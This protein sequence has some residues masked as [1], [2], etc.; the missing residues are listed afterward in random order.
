MKR[1]FLPTCCALAALSIAMPAMAQTADPAAV[2]KTADPAAVAQTA[3]PA[4]SAAEPKAEQGLEDIIV[5]AQRRSESLQRAAVAVDVVTAGDLAQAGV[6]T[7]T[8]LNAAVPSLTVQQGGGANSAFFLRGVGNF[9]ANGYSDPAVAFNLDGVYIGRPSSTTTVFYDLER[10][11]VLKGPQGTLYGRNATGGAVNVIPMKP[12]IGET[13]IAVAAGYG[14]YDARDAEAVVNVALGAKAALRVAGKTVDRDGYNRDGTL[15]DVGQAVRAQLLLEATDRLTLRVAADYAHQGGV[16]PSGSYIGSEAATPGTAATATSPANYTYRPTGLD[17]RLGFRA[18][19]AQA[20]YSRVVI[21]GANINPAPLAAASLDNHYWGV[22]S[23]MTW[24]TEAGTLTVLPSFRRSTLSDVY[25]GPSFRAGLIEETDEQFSVE[26]RFAGKRIGPFD[27]L[28]GAYY[29]DERVD[30]QYALNQYQ[31]ISF[32]DFTSKTRSK[33]VFGRL[34]ANLTDRFRLVGGG[35]YTHDDKDFAAAVQAL[36]DVCTRPTGC[37]G[38]PSL[39]VVLRL[40]DVP[41]G[42]RAPGLAGAVPFGTNGNILLYSPTTID[43]SFAASRFTYR[44]AAEYDLGPRSLLY[45]SYETGYRSGGFSTATGRERYGPEFVDAITIGSKNRFFD[46]RV[47]INIEAFHWKY[48]DQQVSHFG[49]DGVG[50][51]NFF[52]ENIGASTIKGVDVE[53]QVLVT[54][55]TRLNGTVQYLDSTVDRFRYNLP[56]TATS[57][58]PVTGCAVTNGGSGTALTYQVDCSGKPGYNSPRWAVNAGIDQTIPLGALEVVLNG[59]LHYRAN[60]VVGFDYLPQQNTGANTTFDLGAS[61]GDAE[62]RWTL[63]GFVRNV[64]D[65]TIPSYV[66]YSGTLG[67]VVTAI[68]NSPRTYGAR[69]AYKF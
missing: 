48:R 59:A 21:P 41:N 47:Q 44:L 69:L 64:T 30:A 57:L 2:T 6:V 55:T 16:G 35:R 49:L 58:P 52:T 50:N 37:I 19:A 26:A 68:Y 43:Q 45:A 17:P 20:F 53:T 18:P 7:A 51:N 28:I 1:P 40:A 13:S 25:P 15:D 10:I 22:L 34:T 33:A 32:Q 62:D 9:T 42:P 36:V 31:L 24:R 3:D 67:G 14:N 61:I 38:G 56:R 4:A 63:S 66:Q 29:F 60:A 54:P 23:E 65:E 46:N 5:T 27:W 11:E 12:K 8:T 39:P